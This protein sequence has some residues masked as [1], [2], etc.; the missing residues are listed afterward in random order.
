MLEDYCA[1]PP[2]ISLLSA[3][4]KTVVMIPTQTINRLLRDSGDGIYIRVQ[5]DGNPVAQGDH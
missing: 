4:H 3:P 5:M 2:F 1:L